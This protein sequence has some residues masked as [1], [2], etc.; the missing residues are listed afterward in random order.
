M[1]NKKKSQ[2]LIEVVISV[3]LAV[4]VISALLVLG[5]ASSKTVASSLRRT[6][7]TKLAT[8]KVEE[9]RYI[10]DQF[11]YDNVVAGFTSG[12]VSL[13]ATESVE[14]GSNTYTRTVT[15]TTNTDPAYKAITV[16]VKW[17]ETAGSQSTKSV[18]I[19]T[20]LSDWK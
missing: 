17:D 6:Q 9:A 20:I 4:M 2:T 16:M 12:N 8:D 13:P 10:R 7:A 14:V 5:A 11:G 1:P 3:A 18:T 19:P 15:I